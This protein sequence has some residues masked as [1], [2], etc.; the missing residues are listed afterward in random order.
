MVW[1]LNKSLPIIS[2]CKILEPGDLVWSGHFESLTRDEVVEKK[3]WNIYRWEVEGT[4][5][6]G[7][8][9]LLSHSPGD[10]GSLINRVEIITSSQ[11]CKMF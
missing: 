11:P 6:M 10:L 9:C 3:K 4:A 5:A 1:P 2:T 8:T 7:H